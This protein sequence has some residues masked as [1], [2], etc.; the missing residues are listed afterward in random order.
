[1]IAKILVEHTEDLS[2]V[3][4]LLEADP[5]PRGVSRGERGTPGQEIRGG[6]DTGESRA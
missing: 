3:A 2:W 6:P 5:K 4:V 1:M